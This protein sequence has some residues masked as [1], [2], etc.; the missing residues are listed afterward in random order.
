MGDGSN[1]QPTMTRVRRSKK[2]ARAAYDRMSRWYDL[3]AGSEKK[4]VEAGL[5]VL[6]A[7]QSER[8]LEIGFGTGHALL[9]LARAVGAS[10]AVYGVDISAG[11]A[12]VAR[13]RLR[14]AG[15]GDEV[16][17]ICGDGTRLPLGDRSLDGVFL[18]FTLELFDTPNIPR[19]LRA[20]RRV[21]RDQGRLCVVSLAKREK[22]SL[23]V[24]LY[25]W[26]HQ[27]MPRYV[28]CR[29]IP[30]ETTVQEAGFEIA[31]VERRSMWT[32]PVDIVL[33]LKTPGLRTSEGAPGAEATGLRAEPRYAG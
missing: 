31:R 33:G 12:G 10:G 11:M 14:E 15:L 32:L 28:D 1:R 16:A 19:V 23:S 22:D 24:R 9:S 8:M 17:L 2:E 5:R 27:Q 6:G 13:A 21:L 20:C 29:P 26:I 7:E 25:E 3:M 30:V 4:H 18:S